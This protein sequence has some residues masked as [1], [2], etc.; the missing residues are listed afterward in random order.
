MRRNV[1]FYTIVV[2]LPVVVLGYFFLNV[3]TL[4]IIRNAGSRDT[5]VSM[6]V[7]GDGRFERTPDKPL[8]AGATTLVM[9]TAKTQGPLSVT[10]EKDGHWKEFALDQSVPKHFSADLITLQSCDRLVGKR[11]FSF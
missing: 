9:F 3:A 4:A 8:K 11:G 10:C 1:I 2:G 6:L 5:V 7:S